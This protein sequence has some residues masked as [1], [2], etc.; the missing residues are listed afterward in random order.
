ML[1]KSHEPMLYLLNIKCLKNLRNCVSYNIIIQPIK[2]TERDNND[3]KIKNYQTKIF[4][5]D[6]NLDISKTRI[7]K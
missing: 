3:R 1:K 5:I 6:L 7:V 2:M 4:F